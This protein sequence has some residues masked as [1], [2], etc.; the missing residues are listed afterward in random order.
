MAWLHTVIDAPVRLHASTAAFWERALGW[1]P[2]DPW[3]GHPELRSFEPPRGEPYVHLQ[4]VDG[5]PR[6]HVGMESDDPRDSAQDLGQGH[7]GWHV[8]RDPA[9]L[10]FC[11]TENS[12]ER[13]T[14]RDLA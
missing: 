11:A 3:P 9:G 10:P 4:A 8:L 1:S 6:V 5:A 12:P 2:G 14:R 13:T 7:G